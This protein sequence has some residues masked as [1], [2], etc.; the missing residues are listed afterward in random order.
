M[1]RVAT[2]VPVWVILDKG[3]KCLLQVQHMKIVILQDVYV[4][5]FI[6][7]RTLE[8]HLLNM[9]CCCNAVLGV[10]LS[11]SWAV[12]FWHTEAIKMSNQAEYKTWPSSETLII[13]Y[14]VVTE[15]FNLCPFFSGTHCYY[16]C[17]LKCVFIYGVYGDLAVWI[18]IYHISHFTT[19]QGYEE[20]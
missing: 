15:K 6:N 9:R 12:A 16:C 8:K 19:L 18:I 20:Y 10:H 3:I 5:V 14:W 13:L 2:N 7:A 17:S 4:L 11:N 1:G